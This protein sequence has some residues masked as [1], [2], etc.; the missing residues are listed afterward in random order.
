VE[1]SVV[2]P[3]DLVL[4]IGAGLGVLTEAL[5]AVGARVVAVE[6]HPGRAAELRGRFAKRPVVVVQADAAALRLPRR[7]FRVVANPPF[8]IVDHLLRRLLSGGSRM[9]TADL[10]VPRSTARRWNVSDAPGAQRWRR[11]FLLTSGG[12]VPRTAFHPPPP[13]DAVILRIRRRPI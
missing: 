6:L 7:P 12:T 13:R 8:A 5:L 3:R 10:I 2:Q 9:I 4:D 11:Q 1:G